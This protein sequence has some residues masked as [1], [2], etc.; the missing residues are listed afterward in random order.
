MSPSEL[1]RLSDEA[2]VEM[3]VSM[4]IGHQPGALASDD[5]FSAVC[6]LRRRYSACADLPKTPTGRFRSANAVEIDADRWRSAWYRRRLTLVAVSELAGK[7]RVWANA[8]IKRGTV[9][10]W[11]V[12]QLAAELGETTEVLLWEVASDRERLRV[13]LR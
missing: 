8:V 5:V 1:K 2:I 12:D 9:S 11:V 6:E 3:I 4:P 13:A 7:C 10:Y